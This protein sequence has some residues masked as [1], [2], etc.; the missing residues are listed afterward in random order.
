MAQTH[1][2]IYRRYQGALSARR[3][4]F[5]PLVAAGVRV[6]TKKKL[7]LLLLYAPVAITTIIYCFVV[8][9]KYAAEDVA[10]TIGGMQGLVTVFAQK[11]AL[12][13][14]VAEKIADAAHVMRFFTLLATAWYGAGLLAEDRRLGAHL[15]YFARPL[16]RLDYF[17][18]KFLT[19]SFFGAMASVVP[20]LVICFIAAWSS[21]DWEFLTHE[22]DV[23][24]KT[25]AYS[26]LWICVTSSVVLAVS[27][28]VTR[29]TLAL[30]GVFGFF[31]LNHL[32][33][34]VLGI[35]D[36]RYEAI[37]L[38]FDLR[39]VRNEIFG[40]EDWRDLQI[41]LGTA[42]GVLAAAVVLALTIVAARIRRLEVV[43]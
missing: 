40:V 18:G 8:Y 9:G 11:A 36:R 39:R 34:G 35:I 27:S 28:M 29:K 3:L 43:A 42:L 20:G 15:L 30:A 7:P 6:A 37:S 1:T 14:D 38:L 17:L 25:I 22:G 33:G 13:I 41:E 12:H 23:I 32:V 26:A 4:R 16:T 31:I 19:V 21:P 5:W 2:E 10:G 24:L